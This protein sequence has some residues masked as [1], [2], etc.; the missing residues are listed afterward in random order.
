MK[1]K[2]IIKLLCMT[3]GVPVILSMTGCANAV[4]TVTDPRP[5]ATVTSDQ[6][7]T[8]SLGI[9][10]MG[11]QFESDHIKAT[12]YNHRVLLTGQVM[13]EQQHTLAIDQVKLFDSVQKIYD[14]LVIS[15]VFVSTGSNDTYITGQVKTKLVGAE[16]V[17][18]NDGKIVTDHGVVY[19]LGIIEKSQ[20]ANMLSVARSV[21]GVKKVV[22]LVQYK[23]S[24]SKLN[25][26]TSN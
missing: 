11:D 16:N 4:L 20:E 12:V 26:P 22:P 7:I 17:N 13:N 23:K 14:Y 10:Y 19:I 3:F 25:L 24:D 21:D 8:Q 5:V 18:S 2:N 6:Y 1:S 9:K 15:P